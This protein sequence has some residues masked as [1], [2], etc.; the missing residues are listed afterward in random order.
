MSAQGRK[1][2]TRH[3]RIRELVHEEWL[4]CEQP[5]VPTRNIT[6]AADLIRGILE[7]QFFAESLDEEELRAAWKEIAGDFIGSHTKPE[8]VKQGL[9]IL[10]VT[11]PS[12]R[13]HLEQMKAELLSKVQERFGSDKIKSIRF[14]LG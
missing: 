4:G 9:L 13:F 8:S 12:M 6:S 3:E 2:P 11:Q 5:T 14:N 1:K 7:K 10:R